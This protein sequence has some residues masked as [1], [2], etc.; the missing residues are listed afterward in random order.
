MNEEGRVKRAWNYAYLPVIL[1]NTKQILLKQSR[2][3]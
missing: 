2:F 3:Y 1:D